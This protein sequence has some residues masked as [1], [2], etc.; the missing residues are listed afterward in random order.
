MQHPR[1]LLLFWLTPQSF[2]WSPVKYLG[3][4]LF[5]L[6]SSTKSSTINR[7]TPLKHSY[8]THIP[9]KLKVLLV[10]CRWHFITTILYVNGHRKQ[11]LFRSQTYLHLSL[12]SIRLF[13]VSNSILFSISHTGQ[14]IAIVELHKWNWTCSSFL[15]L[16]QSW[17]KWQCWHQRF[18]TTAK[19]KLPPDLLDL[20]TTGSRA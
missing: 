12:I 8:I 1:L 20:I 11:Y 14:T 17:Q 2:T 7:L 5:L 10:T 3:S 6:N 4:T 15:H 9:I 19:K 13:Y 16:I 18:F